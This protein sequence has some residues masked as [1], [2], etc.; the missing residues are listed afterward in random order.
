L[1]LLA[2]NAAAVP[3]SAWFLHYVFSGT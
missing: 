1:N 3:M 2:S